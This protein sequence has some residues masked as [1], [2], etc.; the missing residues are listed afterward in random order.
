MNNPI[1]PRAIGEGDAA[2]YIGMS[3]HFLRLGRQ[4]GRIGK[5]TPPHLK[6]GRRIVYLIEDLDAWLE[7]HRQDAA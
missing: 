7:S 4:A 2:R 3:T 5:R 1:S 6:L